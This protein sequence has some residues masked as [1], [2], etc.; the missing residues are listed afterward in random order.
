M[1]MDLYDSYLRRI[2]GKVTQIKF[3]AIDEIARL[4]NIYRYMDR[5]I[6]DDRLKNHT[7]INAVYIKTSLFSLE[8]R[9]WN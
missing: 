7:C 2:I 3:Q 5:Q 8:N 4:I 6:N 1:K 9:Y